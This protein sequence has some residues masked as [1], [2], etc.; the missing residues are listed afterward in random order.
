MACKH[1]AKYFPV[2]K[3]LALPKDSYAGKVCLVTGGGTGIGKAIARTYSMLGGDVVIAARRLDVLKAT[4]EEIEKESGRKVLPIQMDVRDQESIE[5]CIDKIQERFGKIPNVCLN[6]A[7]GNFISPTERLSQNAFKTVVEIVLL[8]SANVTTA[9]GKRV[10]ADGN[11][12]CSFLYISTPYCRNSAEFVV[13][14]GAAKNGVESL[15]RSLATEWAKHHM[16]FNVIAPGPI[17]TKGAFGN[18][19]NM[20]MEET[21]KLV[22]KHIPVGRVGDLQE[23]ANLASYVTSDYA[24]W[25]NGSVIDFDGGQQYF[26]HPSAFGAVCHKI[27][28]EQWDA[29]RT[30]IDKNKK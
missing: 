25:M 30:K 5:S 16:R 10:I 3:T 23:V 2:L 6:N 29:V 13:P 12:G 18:L 26:N 28:N 9:I 7:A 1:G 21:I 19:S 17:P 24:S 15:A 4:S 11:I 27:P 20:T 22:S 8:G 14:S